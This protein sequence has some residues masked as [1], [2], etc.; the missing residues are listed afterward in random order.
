MGIFPLQILRGPEIPD[1]GIFLKIDFLLFKQ[2]DKCGNGAW[3]A[4]S[5]KCATFVSLHTG[6]HPGCAAGTR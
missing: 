4:L 3:Q 6:A 5:L 1:Y 2:T